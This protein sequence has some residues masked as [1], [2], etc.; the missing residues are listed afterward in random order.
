MADVSFEARLERLFAQPPRVSDPEAFAARV[1]ERLDRE[2]TLRR[3]FI[4]VAGLVGGVIAVTQTVGAEM[5][6]RLGAALGPV[7]QRLA[8]GWTE[9]WSTDL[10]TAS[11]LSG[12]GLWVIAA[13]AGVAATLA[14]GRAADAF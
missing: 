10:Q 5:Y 1:E 11:L 4:G 14:V 12:E 2:W 3:G 7:N 9:L 8:A 6:G 13:L